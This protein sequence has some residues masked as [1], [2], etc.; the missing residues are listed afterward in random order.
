MVIYAYP[1]RGKEAN[2]QNQQIVVGL[3]GDT[4]MIC[5]TSRKDS[6]DTCQEY[7]Q[8]TM[9]SMSSNQPRS[10]SEAMS[11]AWRVITDTLVSSMLTQTTRKPKYMQY[12]GSS[13][14]LPDHSG[15]LHQARKDW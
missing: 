11:R 13:E 7:E 4:P 15:W 3:A 5:S 10:K 2:T 6:R 14:V 9:E 8:A 1:G 12:K